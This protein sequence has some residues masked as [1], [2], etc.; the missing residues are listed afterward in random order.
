MCWTHLQLT[1][2]EWMG[3][4]S[5]TIIDSQ[6]PS[7]VLLIYLLISGNDLNAS[8]LSSALTSLH[9]MTEV[10]NLLV[11]RNGFLEKFS[12]TP[13]NN[14]RSKLPTPVLS[15]ACV[16]MKPFRDHMIRVDA[17]FQL[18]PVFHFHAAWLVHLLHLVTLVLRSREFVASIASW[19][20]LTCFQLRWSEVYGKELS[21]VDR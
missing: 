7:K 8:T 10:G 18:F 9:L 5:R 2:D 13:Y 12:R 4:I 11:L 6:S 15:R 17:H 3:H 19:Y 14:L 16:F 20:A 1:L 21:I